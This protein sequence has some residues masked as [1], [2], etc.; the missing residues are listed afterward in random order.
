[1]Q[2]LD[3]IVHT[4]LLLLFQ[5]GLT[6]FVLIFCNTVLGIVLLQ[7]VTLFLDFFC[8]LLLHGITTGVEHV[9]LQS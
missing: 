9:T 7:L 1:M 3:G 6:Q 8:K 2:L 4:R 5:L